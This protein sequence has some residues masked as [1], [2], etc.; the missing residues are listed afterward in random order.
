MGAPV[1]FGLGVAVGGLIFG[2]DKATFTANF[3]QDVQNDVYQNFDARCEATCSTLA[4]GTVIVIID[5]KIPG[6]VYFNQSCK[7][8]A[9][10]SIDNTAESIVENVLEAAAK[11][12][13]FIQNSLISLGGSTLSH[14]VNVDQRLRNQ[15]SQVL[16][17]SCNATANSVARNT[18]LYVKNSNAKEVAFTQN[19]EVDLNC[20]INNA[21]KIALYN[22]VAAKATQTGTILSWTGGIALIIGVIAVIGILAFVLVTALK[23]KGGKK[24]EVVE[25]NKEGEVV[26]GNKEGEVVEGNKE[27]EVVEGSKKGEVVM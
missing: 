17:A 10:C 25:G 24:G 22:Q 18:L 1:V 20:V 13:A 4:E 23:G 19:N 26:E 9:S 5:S 27:G 7:V 3:N 14:N 16:S 11:Q 21:G 8:K 12:S 2:G 6:G 15:I